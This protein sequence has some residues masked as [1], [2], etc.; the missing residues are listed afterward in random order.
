M[1]GG[2]AL[3]RTNTTYG[4]NPAVIIPCTYLKKII[5]KRAKSKLCFSLAKVNFRQISY[6]VTLN[7]ILQQYNFCSFLFDTLR[8]SVIVKLKSKRYCDKNSFNATK[9]CI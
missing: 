3:I 2:Q 8:K 1:S 9:K 4:T 5:Q 7:T 6:P